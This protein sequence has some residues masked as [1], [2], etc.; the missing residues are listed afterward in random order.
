MNVH[1]S[2]ATLPELDKFLS[3]FHLNI[4]P[5]GRAFK[6]QLLYQ[7]PDRCALDSYL[8]RLIFSTSS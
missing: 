7:G 6:R 4:S 8:P 2:P 3:T 1:A 5:F